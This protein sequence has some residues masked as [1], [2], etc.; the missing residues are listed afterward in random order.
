MSLNDTTLLHIFDKG[1]QIMGPE[2]VVLLSLWILPAVLPLMLAGWSWTSHLLIHISPNW[3]LARVVFSINLIIVVTKHSVGYGGISSFVRFPE[4]RVGVL[5]VINRYRD[6]NLLP[7]QTEEILPHADLPIY[8]CPVNISLF[9]AVSRHLQ[10]PWLRCYLASHNGYGFIFWRSTRSAFCLICCQYELGAES[11]SCSVSLAKTR[12]LRSP[13]TQLYTVYMMDV[14]HLLLRHLPRHGQWSVVD[15][16]GIEVVAQNVHHEEK[17]YIH[18]LYLRGRS[19][20][21]W[22]NIMEVVPKYQ[23]GKQYSCWEAWV[24]PPWR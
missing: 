13:S 12:S 19:H 24:A 10:K 22:D 11:R 17:S 23:L 2:F 1:C 20:R 16:A 18:R 6:C 14:H 4:R 9:N 8:S 21:G 15:Q 3:G 7:G 5:L